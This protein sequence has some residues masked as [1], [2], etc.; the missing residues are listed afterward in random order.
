M[1]WAVWLML[2]HWLACLWWAIGTAGFESYEATMPAY[3]RP[4]R[5][6][7]L[8][9]V[10]WNPGVGNITFGSF[11]EAVTIGHAT[12]AI[13]WDTAFL[14]RYLSALYWALTSLSKVPWVI[15][16][17]A[18]EQLFVTVVVYVGAVV[19]A[20]IFGEMVGLAKAGLNHSIEKTIQINSITTYSHKHHVPFELQRTLRR[21]SKA[22][23]SFA[24]PYQGKQVLNLLPKNL[25]NRRA[26]L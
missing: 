17:S 10:M 5:A 11:A 4:E 16:L 3:S 23:Q 15:A 22:N 12:R 26:R 6:R 20:F 25:R 2:A 8:H 21:W 19:F 9:R 18:P 24:R 7:M 14:Q 1:I 13:D